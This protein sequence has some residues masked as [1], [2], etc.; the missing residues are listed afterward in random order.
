[1]RMRVVSAPKS[2]WRY[3]EPQDKGATCLLLTISGSLCKGKW[4]GKYNQYFIAWAPM[5][6]GDR[7]IEKR[8]REERRADGRY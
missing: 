8:L 7:E 4:Y 1:M 5:P 2:D 3:E 6:D